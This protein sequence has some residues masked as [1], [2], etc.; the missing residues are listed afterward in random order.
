MF[1]WEIRENQNGSDEL[2]HYGILGMK[3]GVRR[4]PEQL[5]HARPTRQE[6][7]QRKK[8]TKDLA[9]SQRYVKTRHEMYED[10][11]K[12]SDE[13]SADYEKAL[14]KTV[15]PWNKKKKQDEIDR[16]SAVLQKRMTEEQ[17]T[18][19]KADRA[20]AIGDEKEK[21]LKS[22][23]D[24]LT[25]KYG[26]ENVKQLKPKQIKAGETFVINTFKVGLRAENFPVIGNSVSAKKIN[27]WERE[28]REEIAKKRSDALQKSR[29]A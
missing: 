24:A 14:S 22:Y 15:F 3:W 1:E 23:V 29:Y 2:T 19:W 8:L 7:K 28:I 5:G 16:T 12:A 20:M 6:R 25:E 17:E 18:R 11:R 27:N 26:I 10:A 21:A 9:A 13:A 4:T